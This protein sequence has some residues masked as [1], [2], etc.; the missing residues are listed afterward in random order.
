MFGVDLS[1]LGIT[2]PEIPYFPFRRSC[3]LSP[4]P[5]YERLRADAPVS[6]V[7]LWDG[8][9]SWLVTRYDDAKAV[10][11]DDRVSADNTRPGYPTHGPGL[12]AT[13]RSHP[14]FIAMDRPDHLRYRR[15][16]V[17][18]FTARRIMSHRALIQEIVNRRIENMIGE[19]RRA[20]SVDLVS[21]FALPVP[22]A[23]IGH[24]LGV[25]YTDHAFFES[26]SRLMMS[27]TTSAEAATEANDE[28]CAY[29]SRQI[30]IKTEKPDSTL[31]SEL[32]SRL[33]AGDIS[34][35]QAVNTA[36]LILV[37][38]H[39]TTASM[40]A[41]GTLT[42]LLHPAISTGIR[43]HVSDEEMIVVV[44]EL[45]RYLSIAHFGRRRV[46]VADVPIAEHIIGPGEGI[47]VATDSA[48]HDPAIFP[49]PATFNPASASAQHMAFGYGSH[50]CLGQELARLV[51]RIAL[52]T[53][54]MRLPGIE[55]ASE[56]SELRF[57]QENVFYGLERLPVAW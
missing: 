19:H 57:K 15:M 49:E 18:H 34:P 16:L 14:T 30:R 27:G 21:S 42:L 8:S 54:F 11:S 1:R 24:V 7:T 6:Q 2:L 4:A 48:N 25:P 39:E 56:I 3:P 47:I 50:Q 12:A 32:A 35:D 51:L 36:R 17:R 41:L 38:G 23:V 46:A 29:L 40:I 33:A 20:H 44:E 53:L 52:S 26:K 31:L 37:A 22:S 5:D 45:L 13:R 55:L 28:L 9:V 10:L 43:A